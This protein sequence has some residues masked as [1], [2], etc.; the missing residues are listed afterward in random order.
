M[1]ENRRQELFKKLKEE[2]DK[3]R[4]SSNHLSNFEKKLKTSSPK[5]GRNILFLTYKIAAVF[6]LGIIL[7]PMINGS[8]EEVHPE[9]R[10]YQETKS[11]F[12]AYVNYEIGK[13]KEKMNPENEALIIASLQEVLKLQQAY[14]QLEQDFIEQNYDKRILKRMIDNFRQ[15]LDI[16]EKIDEL[17]KST[18]PNNENDENIA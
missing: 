16:L 14:A 3:A 5:K 10:K 18:T 6:I 7:F 4:L 1:Q 13:N 2:E 15:Q 12:T 11:Y 8:H 9:F 17:L